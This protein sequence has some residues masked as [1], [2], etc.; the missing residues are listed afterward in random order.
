MPKFM[1]LDRRTVGVVDWSGRR[2]TVHRVHSVHA[3]GGPFSH[4]ARPP[5]DRRSRTGLQWEALSLLR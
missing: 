4:P 5:L 2:H 1:L 3:G